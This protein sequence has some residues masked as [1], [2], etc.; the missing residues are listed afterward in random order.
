MA[1]RAADASRSAPSVVA[2]LANSPDLNVLIN[3]RRPAICAISLDSVQ[4][5]ALDHRSL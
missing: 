4:P 3:D 5:F 1:R 2:P